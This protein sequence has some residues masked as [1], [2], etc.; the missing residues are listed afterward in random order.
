MIYNVSVLNKNIERLKTI[1][2]SLQKYIDG[3]TV[4]YDFDI[5]FYN[6]KDVL[7]NIFNAFSESS[8]YQ[9]T[10]LGYYCYQ[11]QPQFNQIFSMKTLEDEENAK[12]VV[13]LIDSL[14]DLFN[15]VE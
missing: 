9:Y 1:K 12:E 13:R 8:C 11:L 2:N 4:K 6:V 7:T 14:L 3:N 15:Q 10:N 5:L